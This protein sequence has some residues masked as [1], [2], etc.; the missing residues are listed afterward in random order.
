MGDGL[1]QGSQ[2][3]GV[4]IIDPIKS[5][6][7]GVE[8]ISR[9]LAG[10]IDGHVLF[11][12]QQPALLGL[13]IACPDGQR[14][15]HQPGLLVLAAEI[16]KALLAQGE[17][18]TLASRDDHG[19]AGLSDPALHHGRDGLIRCSFESLPEMVAFGAGILVA[20]EIAAHPLLIAVMTD[21]AFDHAQDAGSLVV[22]DRCGAGVYGQVLAA[23][24]FNGKGLLKA[25]AGQRRGGFHVQELV[26]DAP[27]GVMMGHHAETEIGGEAFIEPEIFPVRRRDQVAEP[28]MGDFMGDHFADALSAGLGG[29]LG[30]T[31][32]QVFA[33]GDG[34]PVFHGA[35]GEIGHGDQI[36]FGQR[37]RDAIIVFAILQRLAAEVQT[38]VGGVPQPRQMDHPY[39]RILLVLYPLEFAHAEKEQ[40]GGHVRRGL[41]A[42]L[43]TVMIQR[44]LLGRQ[45]V[46]EHVQGIRHGHAQLKGRL[47]QGVVQ[48]GKGLA[49]G[50]LLELGYGDIL[51]LAVLSKS[52]AIKARHLIVYE[53]LVIDLY[54]DP[55]LP[56]GRQYNGQGLFV[57]IHRERAVD[58]AAAVQQ[59]ASPNR[60]I[61]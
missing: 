51:C 47:V 23:G 4:V 39:P 15:W 24:N 57:R 60:Q 5:G 50:T 13:A 54:R 58:P 1:A 37:I 33:E 44:H 17:L 32:Q 3:V 52:A 29:Q 61:L 43:F 21:M 22:D 26:P 6:L 53:P 42:H 46:G 56:C 36:H 16:A 30:K 45:R 9:G 25:V 48:T 35:E 8:F 38:E 20:L 31:Q 55:A 11:F 59:K 40:V 19:M 14:G 34:T 41:E 49:G 12:K 7:T 28:L 18:E 10:E 27:L 2:I